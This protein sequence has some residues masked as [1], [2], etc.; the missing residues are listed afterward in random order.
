MNS[1]PA[2]VQF[3]FLPPD[4]PTPKTHDR[5]LRDYDIGIIP[6]YIQVDK[7]ENAKLPVKAKLF[8]VR[9]DGT[10]VEIK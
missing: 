2:I 3:V 10:M 1:Y 9:I 6:W 4:A 5:M 7:P 8:G